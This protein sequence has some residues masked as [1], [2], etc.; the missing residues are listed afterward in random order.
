[1]DK[2]YFPVSEQDAQ[3]LVIGTKFNASYIGAFKSKESFLHQLE[4][5]PQI[6]KICRFLIALEVPE[7]SLRSFPKE[8]KISL[9]SNSGAVIVEKEIVEEICALV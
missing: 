6:T 8:G 1:M 9:A 5:T 2:I 3:S 7:E 4:V